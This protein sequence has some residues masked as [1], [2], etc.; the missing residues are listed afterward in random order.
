MTYRFGSVRVDADARSISSAAGS[1]HLTRKAFDL[2]LL[3][4]EHRPGPMQ[5]RRIRFTRDWWLSTF[6]AGPVQ[7][8]IHD[9]R[10]AID[11]RGSRTS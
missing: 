8:L 11:D 6:V 4:L 10:Q 9:I 1:V 2:L 7:T 3:L 5:S